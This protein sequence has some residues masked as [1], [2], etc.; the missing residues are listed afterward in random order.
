MTTLTSV[1]I[2]RVSRE[3]TVA[4]LGDLLQSAGFIDDRQRG[5][6]E[7]ADRQWRAQVRTAKGRLEDEQSPFK[8]IAALNLT[9]ASG[10]AT[11]IDDFLMARLLAEDAHLPFYKIDALKLDV[12]LIETKI[13][14]PF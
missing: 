11:R 9:D 7:A 10:N 14:R 6:I 2:P 5:D 4:Y 12:A 3:I 8:V 1:P 13:A